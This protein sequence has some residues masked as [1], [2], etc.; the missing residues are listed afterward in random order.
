M[1]LRM[2]RLGASQERGERSLSVGRR[3]RVEALRGELRSDRRREE[4]VMEAWIC[5]RTLSPDPIS[6]KL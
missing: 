2:V 4:A 1:G 3:G 5:D 6:R